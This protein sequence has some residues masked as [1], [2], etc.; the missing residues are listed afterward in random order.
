[1]MNEKYSFRGK[2][3]RELYIDAEL[4]EVNIAGAFGDKALP[5]YKKQHLNPGTAF[6]I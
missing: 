3:F 5:I 2:P 1:M 4:I 6:Y